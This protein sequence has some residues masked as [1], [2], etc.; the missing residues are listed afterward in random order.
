M[1]NLEGLKHLFS[2]LK[3]KQTPKKHQTNFVGW[4]IVELM[5]QVLLKST[6]NAIN[7]TN[8]L[9]MN[10]NEVMTIDNA[11]WISLHLCV[12]KVDVQGT[13]DNVYQLML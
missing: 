5:N 1:T 12:E 11:S 9:S 7:A 3:V 6:P 8:F 2:L 13:A 4:G 10:V